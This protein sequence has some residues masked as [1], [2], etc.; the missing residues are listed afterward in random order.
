MSSRGA[1]DDIGVAFR[2]TLFAV[3]T[4]WVVATA[5]SVALVEFP[6]VAVIRTRQA[7]LME[8]EWLAATS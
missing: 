5:I 4:I 1:R 6:S 3:W 2:P 8:I 7:M